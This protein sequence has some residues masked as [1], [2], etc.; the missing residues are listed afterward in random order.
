[1]R[2]VKTMKTI[3]LSLSAQAIVPV[4]PPWPKQ[5]DIF[6]EGHNVSKPSALVFS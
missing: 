3:F 2:F 5:L 6:D 1:M 4:K